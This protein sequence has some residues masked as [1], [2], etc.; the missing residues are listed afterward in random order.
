MRNRFGSSGRR[1][2][3]ED[4]YLRLLRASRSV[5]IEVLVDLAPTLPEPFAFLARRSPSEHLTPSST[6]QLDDS[7]WVC[8]QV[9]AGSAAPQPFMAIETWLGPSSK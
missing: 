4:D 6:R 7:V 2:R 5:A 3:L 9:Q 1:V 8:L